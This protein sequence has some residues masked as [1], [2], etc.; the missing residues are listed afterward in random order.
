MKIIILWILS[1][2]IKKTCIRTLVL[3]SGNTLAYQNL[4]IDR[5]CEPIKEIMS[6]L[7]IGPLYN[8]QNAIKCMPHLAVQGTHNPVHMAQ[9]IL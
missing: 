2:N 9:D 8:K 6:G 1:N 7:E 4:F 5:S 3:Q